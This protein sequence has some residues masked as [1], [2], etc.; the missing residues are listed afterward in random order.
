MQIQM[1]NI[2][3]R[4]FHSHRTMQRTVQGVKRYIFLYRT[5]NTTAKAITVANSSAD[6]FPVEQSGDTVIGRDLQVGGNLHVQG[7]T[8]QINTTTT[9][10]RDKSIVLGAQSERKTGAT[11]TAASVAV[12]TS[13][14]HGLNNDD[15]IFIVSSTGTGIV[16]EQLS[17]LQILRPILLKQKQLQELISILVLIQLHEHFLGLD[18]KQTID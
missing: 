6:I 2:L 10:A 5:A 11:Y 16:S 18:H 12:V 8:T 4:C 7:T 1:Q 3:V 13:T 14:S 15:I 17:R 9:V